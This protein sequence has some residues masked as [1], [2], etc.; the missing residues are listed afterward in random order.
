[1]CGQPQRCE[2][3]F[4]AREKRRPRK[5]IAADLKQVGQEIQMMP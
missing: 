3:G 1:M 4:Q 5:E 2:A